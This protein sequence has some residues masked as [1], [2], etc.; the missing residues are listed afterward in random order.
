[1]SNL[2]NNLQNGL[3]NNPINNLDSWNDSHIYDAIVEINKYGL[4]YVVI[5]GMIREIN[6][7]IIEK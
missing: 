1:M 6:K 3:Q 4:R 2:Q 5:N 7:L